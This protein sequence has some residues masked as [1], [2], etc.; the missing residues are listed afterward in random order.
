MGIVTPPH[1]SKGRAPNLNGKS[2][3][4]VPAT[5]GVVTPARG[6][7]GAPPLMNG[8]GNPTAI[9]GYGTIAGGPYD[10]TRQPQSTRSSAGP[11]R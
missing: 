4:G 6:G 8:K 5:G 1:G 9:P 7:K 10:P 2:G 11:L 3:P